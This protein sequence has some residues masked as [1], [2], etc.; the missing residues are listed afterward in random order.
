MTQNRKFADFDPNDAGRYRPLHDFAPLQEVSNIQKIPCS[1]ETA[2]NLKLIAPP[3]ILWDEELPFS[4]NIAPATP[5]ELELSNVRRKKKCTL[6]RPIFSQSIGQ[7][8]R[9]SLASASN[10]NEPLYFDDLETPRSLRRF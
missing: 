10:P 4:H 5:T 7:K 2:Q 3:P 1:E 6:P 9:D 8:I